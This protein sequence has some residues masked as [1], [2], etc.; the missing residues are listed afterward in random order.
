V[1]STP[2][3]TNPETNPGPAP[4]RVLI[5]EDDPSTAF[6]FKRL[7]QRDGYELSHAADGE[8]ALQELA[9]KKY[10]AV[11]LDLMM[12]KID[13]LQVLKRLR[14][15]SLNQMVPVIVITAARLRVAEEEA[16]R[17]GAKLFL[18]K[19]QTDQMVEGLRKIMKERA[20][21]PAN[22]LRMATPGLM[23]PQRR[24]DPA[25]AKP[26]SQTLNKIFRGLA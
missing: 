6:I 16:L 10:D 24:Q 4:G 25:P 26:L 8:A 11:I 23:E 18:D 17:Y 15:E 5:V 1:N 2:E 19:T 12:P 7:L 21:S 20:T 14:L 22:T 13:G 3:N 9:Q